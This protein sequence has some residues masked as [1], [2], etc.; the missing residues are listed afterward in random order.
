MLK[1]YINE[2]EAAQ[3][4]GLEPQTLTRWRTAKKG[5]R[6]YKV[7]GAVRY[8]VEDLEAFAQPQGDAA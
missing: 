1:N 2:K 8:T 3:Y 6:F 7:G 4:L 5:P